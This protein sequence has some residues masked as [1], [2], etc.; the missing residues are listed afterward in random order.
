MNRREGGVSANQLVAAHRWLAGRGASR[1]RSSPSS[2]TKWHA[3]SMKDVAMTCSSCCICITSGRN[4][5]IAVRAFALGL[6]LFGL[7]VC[8]VSH[9]GFS[10]D[11]GVPIGILSSS[12][13]HAAAGRSGRDRPGLRDH[14]RRGWRRRR[15][16]ER[17]AR[18]AS[19]RPRSHRRHS[20]SCGN[21]GQHNA[22]MCGF[23]HARGEYIVTLDDDLQNPPEE[24]PKLL[25]RIRT[26]QFDLVY[27]TY[28]V[29][30]AQPLEKRR[31]GVRQRLLPVRLQKRRHDHLVPRDS[32]AAL[33]E[34]LSVRLE[35]HVR[36]RA[37]RVEY[38]ADRPGRGR[39]SSARRGPFGL[40]PEEAG[41]L[42]RSTSSRTSRCCLF[43][44]VSWCGLALSGIGFSL[45]SSISSSRFDRRSS[46]PDM[47]PPSS[48]FWSW[49]NA[50]ARAGHRSASISVGCIS[51]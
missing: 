37:A 31:V 30:A 34:H 11:S 28:C 8:H 9:S 6:R 4:V 49:G 48:R 41:L 21:Y 7:G 17:A 40:Q 32:P 3:G 13:G 20:S 19:K 15:V 43:R 10:G 39:A 44:I 18:A 1:S 26:G 14:F 5:P 12:L 35:L 42:S 50:T 36:R 23:R 24:I 51:T 38:S 46:C 45:G 33:G 2:R 47:P 22:L 27:G 29:E 25:D 16:L